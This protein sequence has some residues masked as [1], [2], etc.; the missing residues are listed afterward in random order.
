MSLLITFME[1]ELL[2]VC[3]LLFPCILYLT[4]HVL[5][6]YRDL[7]DLKDDYKKYKRKTSRRFGKID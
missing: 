4:H 2:I 5:R 3:L 6:L 1:I 7:N